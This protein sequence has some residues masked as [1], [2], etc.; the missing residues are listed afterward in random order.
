[1]STKKIPKFTTRNGK[2]RE[3]NTMGWNH[4]RIYFFNKVCK[5]WKKPASK[6]KEGTWEQLEVEWNDYI[7]DNISLYFFGRS[8]KRK[9]N[10]STDSEEMSPLP[11]PMQALEIRL[12]DNDGYMPDCPCKQHDFDYDSPSSQYINRVSNSSCG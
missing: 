1:M 6:N 10:N 9:S 3:L 11:P 4:E 5:E 7:E 8:R 2:K 12:D